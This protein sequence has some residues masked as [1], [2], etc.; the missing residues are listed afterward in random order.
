MLFN[1]IEYLLLFLPVTLLVFQVCFR[2]PSTQPKIMW[3]VLASLVFYG[4][5]NPKYLSLIV[6]SIL[7]NFAIGK[8]LA[9]N[10]PS[11]GSWLL[12]RDML[13]PGTARLFQI[14]GL[15][16]YWPEFIGPLA[17]P[18]TQEITLPLAISFFTFQQVTSPGGCFRGVTARNTS[19]VT[20]RC[21]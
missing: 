20:M 14:H 12:A 3:L 16:S 15:L 8:A 7:V 2:G 6:V 18:D 10:K 4:S 19:S 21:L 11:K 1:S 5:W 13:Q 9:R 17:Y